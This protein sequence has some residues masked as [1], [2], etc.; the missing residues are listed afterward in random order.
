MDW[1]FAPMMHVVGKW[2]KMIKCLT[3][4]TSSL[5]HC[6]TSFL[7]FVWHKKGIA[8]GLLYFGTDMVLNFMA[9]LRSDRTF[10]LAGSS[11]FKASLKSA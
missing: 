11:M 3:D 8:K 9:F 6:C 7:K 4:F 5:S 1:C 2:S 10:V